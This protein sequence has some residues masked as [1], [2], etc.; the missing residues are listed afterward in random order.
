MVALAGKGDHFSE[1]HDLNWV[2]HQ[3][4]VADILTVDR[5]DFSVYR[6]PN[7]KSLKLV[8]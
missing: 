8:L 2:A 7:G 6:L 4:G 1:G 5:K 3:T